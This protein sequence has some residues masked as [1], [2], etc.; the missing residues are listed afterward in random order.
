MFCQEVTSPLTCHSESADFEVQW[1]DY[2]GEVWIIHTVELLQTK[3]HNHLPNKV[4]NHSLILGNKGL[5]FH[6]SQ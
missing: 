3:F 4:T 1:S 5:Y 2:A 6:S